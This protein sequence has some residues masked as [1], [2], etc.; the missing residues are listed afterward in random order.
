VV[1]AQLEQARA[2]RDVVEPHLNAITSE[3]PSQDAAGL[4]QEATSLAEAP[5]ESGARAGALDAAADDEI[6]L[7]Q[8]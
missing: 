5:G 6:V 1:F 8:R 4:A 3:A 2:S 7:R